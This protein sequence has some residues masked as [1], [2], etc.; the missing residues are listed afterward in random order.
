MPVQI[1]A[2]AG[3]FGELEAHVARANPLWQRAAGEGVVIFQGPD[4]YITPSWYATKAASAKVVPTWN[5]AVVHAQGPLRAIEDAAW[6]HGLVSDLTRRHEGPRAHPW[7]VSDAPDEYVQ[8]ILRAIVGIEIPLT[9]LVGKWKVTQNRGE[10]DR[11]S[12][13]TGLGGEAGDDAAAMA[14]LVRGDST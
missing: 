1:D 7:Q 14:A 6:L 4:R 12:V 9:S 13:A 11:L 10:A 5:Y 2:A 3:P 8:Q